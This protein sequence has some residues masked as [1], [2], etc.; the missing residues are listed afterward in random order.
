M[1]GDVMAWVL[2]MVCIVLVFICL[3]QR[4]ELEQT[5]E[6]LTNGHKLHQKIIANRD[7]TIFSQGQKIERLTAQLADHENAKAERRKNLSDWGKAGRAKQL[8]RF[9]EPQETGMGPLLDGAAA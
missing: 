2:G 3:L 8:G 9:A 6:A 4:A 7:G 1:S 5:R